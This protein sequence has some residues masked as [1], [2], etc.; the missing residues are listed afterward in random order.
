MAAW[1]PTSVRIPMAQSMWVAIASAKGRVW[2]AF[3]TTRRMLSLRRAR[4]S[5]SDAWSTM[6]EM[7]SGLS[8]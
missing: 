4:S 5:T 8:R 7:P 6:A 3:S 1:S 2:H